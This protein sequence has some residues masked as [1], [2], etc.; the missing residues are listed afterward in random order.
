MRP[1]L[2]DTTLEIKPAM[3][4]RMPAASTPR[5]L[6]T[7]VL[8]SAGLAAAALAAGCSSSP[9]GSTA[10]ADSSSTI[11]AVGAEN[12]YANVISQIG[13]KYVHVTAIESNP[14]TDPH[15]FEAS[16]SVAQLVSSA[17]LVV[18]NGIGYDSYMNK[19]ESAAPNAHRKVID[20]QNLLGLPDSTPNP[21]LWYKPATMPAV[22]KAVASDLAS[23]QPSHASY[24]RA[25]A[26]AFDTS[27]QPWYQA[28]ATFKAA[29]PG[30]P[31][32][33]TEP[34]GDYMLQAAGARI[35][36]P[37]GFQA[38]VMNG[39]DLVPAVRGAGKQPVRPAQ[40][41]GVPVQPAGD[42][43]THRIVPGQRAQVRNT[44][45]GRVRDHADRL[46]L[47]V[48][49]AGRGAR[50]AAGGRRPR[51]HPEARVMT[52][53]PPARPAA[54]PADVLSVEDLNVRLGG[55]Q[56]LRDVSFTMG[57]GEFTGLIGANGAGKTTLLKVILGLQPPTSGTVRVAGQ[58]RTRR[59]G[60]V[61]YVPQ[62]IGLDPDMPLRARDLVG[63]GLDGQR[64]G[65]PLPS[66]RRRKLVDEMLSAVGAERFADSRVGN[67][68][69]GEQQRVMIAHA[70]ISRPRLLLLDE[71][72]AN[73][74]I[75]SEQDVVSLLGQVARDQGVAVLISA[76]D[77][78]PLLPVMDRIVYLAGGRAA[79]GT[80]ERGGPHRRAQRPVRPARG[81]YPGARPDP[82][83]GR[84]RRRYPGP[85][86][87]RG[88]ARRAVR[89]RAAARPAPGGE[90][91][92]VTHLLHLIIE[93]GFFG[94][95]PV[96][97]AL[98]AGGLVAVVSGIVG[99]FTVVRGQS[100]AGHALADI[101]VTGGSASYLA[102]VS[103]LW[104]FAGV[105]VLAAGVMDM[106]GVQR[107]RGRDLATGIV[108]GAGLGLARAVP[109]LRHHAH[110]H[111][112]G[113]DHHPVRLACSPSP[114]RSSR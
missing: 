75:G 96:R 20:V 36:T 49:D 2:R 88:R 31:V 24:F 25:R 10:A 67:L 56:I 108:R 41:Q 69:G 9:E 63:L 47:P 84:A 54:S 70:L 57:E 32:A 101:S 18:Q 111:H 71:P 59:A 38:D 16:A 61:G 52:G 50:A 72:L 6:A 92:T 46:H 102:G 83:G 11:V 45:G 40:G 4:I 100:Y 3:S 48:L 53:Q 7:A 110:Q 8:A 104:G 15:S 112:R 1:V 30:T 85:G 113:D 95:A 22:A 66:A 81:R 94:N 99:S 33:V 79:T 77:M 13:G 37:F 105:G 106:I 98:L 51:V 97:S 89:G 39:V 80:T 109:V 5:R 73:L 107:P 82:G 91:L 29:H 68:S 86:A 23:I 64:L 87:V 103:P 17:S 60:L 14:N 114:A 74:D 28:L 55:R 34:V 93:P 27:L 35:L 43:R 62:K 26:A 90:R 78:N 44:G 19:I 76:H 65:L 42:R 12:E 58:S 21:H